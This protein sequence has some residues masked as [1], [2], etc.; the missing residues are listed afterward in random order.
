MTGPHS[1]T[2]AQATD[3]KKRAG[4]VQQG[5]LETTPNAHPRDY[6]FPSLLHSTR[7]SPTHLLQPQFVKALRCDNVSIPLVA[8]F[9]T[10]QACNAT[11]PHEARFWSHQHVVLRMRR[12]APRGAHVMSHTFHIFIRG[13]TLKRPMGQINRILKRSVV[14]QCRSQI[15]GTCSA[16]HPSCA[17]GEFFVA[18]KIS[19]GY[20]GTCATKAVIISSHRTTIFPASNLAHSN[21]YVCRPVYFSTS[22][23]PYSRQNPKKA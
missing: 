11:P 23:A 20:P 10:D 19:Q 13:S 4:R 7:R 1:C 8:H 15:R 22:R 14:L 18:Y 6:S 9:M 12:T 5:L 17:F 2:R 16:M 3:K 21:G